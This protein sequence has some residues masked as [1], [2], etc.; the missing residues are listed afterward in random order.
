MRT[1]LRGDG[2][3]SPNIR[4]RP[5]FSQRVSAS[6]VLVRTEMRETTLVTLLQSLL[7]HPNLDAAGQEGPLVS[8]RCQ[9]P[10]LW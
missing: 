7:G 3:S 6:R 1:D 10:L 4:E 2:R 5:F 9:Q 8:E